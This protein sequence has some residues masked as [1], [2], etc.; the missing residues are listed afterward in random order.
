MPPSSPFVQAQTNPAPIDEDKQRL[1]LVIRQI[2]LLALPVHLVL[3]PTFFYFELYGLAALNVVSIATWIYSHI[4]NNRGQHNTAI[5]LQVGEVVVHS[6]VVSVAIGWDYGFQYYLFGAIPFV[7]F[8]TNLRASTVALFAGGL[9]LLFVGL[10]YAAPSRAVILINDSVV[11]GVYAGNALV[12]F[13]AVG[14]NSLYFRQGSIAAEAAYMA[15]RDRADSLLLNVLPPSVADRLKTAPHET[16]ADRYEH[17]TVLF[18]DLVG[19]TPASAVMEPEAMVEL[20]N[21]LFSHFDAICD[22]CGAEK[23]KTIG[24][25]YMAICGAPIRRSDH[26]RVMANVALE[27]RDHVAARSDRLPIQIRIGLNSGEVV[28]AIVGAT[29]FHYDVFSDTVNVAA[30]MESTGVP[31]RVHISA[32]TRELLGDEFRYEPRGMIQVKGKG[33]METF[34]LEGHQDPSY[35]LD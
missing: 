4:A 29:R 28:G 11:L 27:I 6:A 17:V 33:Q 5:A 7:M 3:A 32:V 20:L 12:A 13:A 19:F 21:D 26:A 35:P 25:G 31:G 2:V 16:I 34:F 15:Q 8:N 10:F 23:I 1:F 24:D 14:M 22:L 30:R 18:A 9:S